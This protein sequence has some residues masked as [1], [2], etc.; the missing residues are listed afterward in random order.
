M[1]NQILRIKLSELLQKSRQA[2]RLYTSF[3][4]SH[5]ESTEYTELQANEWKNVN[6]EL[7]KQL[8]FM[9]NSAEQKRLVP[10]VFN[11]RD[12]IQSEFRQLETDLHEKQQELIRAS[13]HGDFIK[14]ATL[15]RNLVV[16]KARMQAS[17]AAQHELQNVIEKSRISPPLHDEESVRSRPEVVIMKPKIAQVI[18]LR[19]QSN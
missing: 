14:A 2:I 8:S 11:F 16:I 1:S 10:D 9:L 12:R 17:G 3:S 13:E 15:S 4:K 19:R 7:V 6:S 18:P 5:A